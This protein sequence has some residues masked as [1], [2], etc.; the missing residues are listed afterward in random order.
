MNLIFSRK[1]CG[2]EFKYFKKTLPKGLS[3]TFWLL[4]KRNF[5]FQIQSHFWF[6]SRWRE[7]RWK[8]LITFRCMLVLLL[9]REKMRV[10]D[11]KLN[12]KLILLFCRQSHKAPAEFI[13]KCRGSYFLKSKMCLQIPKWW[14]KGLNI[15]WIKKINDWNSK[16]KLSKALWI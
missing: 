16:L 10:S 8:K 1:L 5:I 6:V 4:E 7:S 12:Q 9:L 3:S 2:N 11:K 13:M 15:C 14:K